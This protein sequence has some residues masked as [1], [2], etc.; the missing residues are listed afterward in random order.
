MLCGHCDSADEVVAK[1]RAMMAGGSDSRLGKCIFK[2]S[3]IYN[4]LRML[5]E[6]C[7]P[8]SRQMADCR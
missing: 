2:T 3:Y 8:A 6:E 5:V 4:V 7:D 1:R